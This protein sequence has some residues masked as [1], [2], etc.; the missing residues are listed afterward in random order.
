MMNNTIT[1]LQTLDVDVPLSLKAR[2]VAIPFLL[3]LLP[4]QSAWAQDSAPI[5]YPEKAMHAVITHVATDPEGTA[6]PSW[7]LSGV[8]YDDFSIDGG[9]LSFKSPPNF[10]SPKD[11]DMNNIYSVDIVASDGS[12]SSKKNVMVEVT[13]VEEG[14]EITFSALQPQSG[15]Q[16][17]ATLTD[18]DGDETQTIWQWAKSATKDGSYTDIANATSPSYVPA[19]ADDLHYLRAMASYSDEEGPDKTAMEVSDYPVQRVHGTNQ[20]PKFTAANLHLDLEVDENPSGGRALGRPIMATDGNGDVLTYSLVLEDTNDDPTDGV[21][22]AINR[23]TGQLMT[24][25][26]L[27]FE[28][29]VDVAYTGLTPAAPAD[30]ENIDD[31]AT[32]NVYKVTV[33]ATDPAGIPDTDV[34][35]SATIVVTITVTDEEEGPTFTRTPTEDLMFEEGTAIT[36]VLATFTGTDQDTT[37]IPTEESVATSW[38]VGGP[39]GSKFAISTTGTPGQLTF[40]AA[41]NFE[42]PGDADKNNVYEVT[43]SVESGPEPGAKL[44]GSTNVKIMLTDTDEAGKVALSKIQPRIG[45][46]V[47]ASLSDPDGNLS[48]VTWEWYKADATDADPDA[49]PPTD[50]TTGAI[51]DG[52]LVD[53]P[54]SLTIIENANSDAY[55]PIPEDFMDDCGP[56]SVRVKPGPDSG[57]EIHRRAWRGE[58]CGHPID[59]SRGA[60]HPE[61][62]AGVR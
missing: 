40:K 11:A 39:D 28:S 34:A 54:P 48:G 5:K 10:E 24:K 52:A 51:D 58:D 6:V 1:R 37:A 22:F 29:A 17:T 16:F 46:A 14:G 27:N 57:C 44:R 15:T 55:T 26:K 25:T 21:Q 36:T 4:G 56:T 12:N 3:A 59:E 53:G 49:D 33:K 45:L 47:K 61:Q 41:P 42:S 32:N 62:S 7:S 13:D 9:V 35:N 30:P 50:L 18:P 20:A 2:L 43:V 19:D 60:G 23:A 38:Q 8:D 31:A